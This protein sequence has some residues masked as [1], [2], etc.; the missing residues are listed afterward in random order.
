M[1]V[2]PLV[3]FVNQAEVPSEER[4]W[5]VGVEDEDQSTSG[6]L[7]A[8]MLVHPEF[9]MGNS[10]PKIKQKYHISNFFYDG[11]IKYD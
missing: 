10:A 7:S 1:P 6:R 3:E 4:Q 8:G 2:S 11:N 9:H 5:S